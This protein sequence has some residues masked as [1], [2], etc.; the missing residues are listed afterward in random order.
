M[1]YRHS[2]WSA[3]QNTDKASIKRSRLLLITEFVTHLRKS[4]TKH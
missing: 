3:L 1:I 2:T 4:G